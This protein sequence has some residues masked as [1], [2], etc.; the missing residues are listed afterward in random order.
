MKKIGVAGP[1]IT[2]LEI[3]YVTDAATNAWFAD[4]SIYHQRFEEAFGKKIGTKYAMALPS[5]TSALHLI[6]AA[7]EVGPGDEVIVPDATWIAS[8]AP[9]SYVGATPV[10]VDIDPKTWCMDAGAFER[11]ISEKTKAA[12]VVDLYGGM[13]EWDALEKIAN[14]HNI[15]LIED[16]AEAVGSQYRGRMAGSFGVV[17]TFSFHGS[18]TMTTGE[19]GMLVTDDKILFERAQFLRDHGRPAGDRFFQNTEV[20]FKYKMSSMQAAMGLAQ[21]ERLDELVERKQEI[22]SWYKRA[23]SGCDDLVLN[24]QPEDVINTYW[25]VTAILDQSI[26]FEKLDLMER[27]SKH[28]IDSR[29][30]FHPLSSL[31]AYEKTEQAIKA[32]QIN[33]IAYDI[34][35][36]GINLPSGF[37]LDEE[38][39]KYICEK[40]LQIIE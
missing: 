4:H 33:K 11:A 25:M 36:R 27:L 16:A 10:F 2:E 23:L 14:T 29:P 12:I 15:P 37:Q 18:K 20:G 32:Q 17:G 38:N 1:S 39:V 28:G 13:P 9:I 7:L 24:Y 31:H 21:T 35:P 22:F 34:S 3:S 8:S 19:G 5:C 30:F 6:L 40:L 26:G